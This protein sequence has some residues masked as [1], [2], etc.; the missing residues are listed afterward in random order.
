VPPVPAAGVPD[1]VAVPLACATNV[2]P[3]GNDPVSPIVDVGLPVE[4]TVKLPEDPTVNVAEDPDVMAGAASMV[5]V[6]DCE[7]LGLT[8]FDALIVI[9]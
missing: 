9:G 5:R 8:P 7:P 2:T 4:V 3:E 1:N 6:K